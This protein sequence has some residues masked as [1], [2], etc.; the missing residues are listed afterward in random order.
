MRH[1]SIS[2][3]VWTTLSGRDAEFQVRDALQFRRPTLPGPSEP[4]R[5]DLSS[6]LSD[7]LWHPTENGAPEMF[8]CAVHSRLP[9]SGFV[10]KNLSFPCT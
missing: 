1:F 4:P 7:L 3:G 9:L 8:L 5:S 6:S 10:Q 2:D